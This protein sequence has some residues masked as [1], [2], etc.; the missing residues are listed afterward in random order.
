MFSDFAVAMYF[1]IGSGG[2]I[3]F[4]MQRKT[5]GNTVNSLVVAVGAGLVGFLII[6]T[7]LGIFF[8]Q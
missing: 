3:Y 8:K 7:L 5:G 1:A 6:F 4:K 2:W